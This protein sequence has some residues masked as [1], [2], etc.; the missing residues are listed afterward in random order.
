MAINV[1]QA[2]NVSK[3]DLF[4]QMALR[5]SCNLINMSSQAQGEAYGVP[6]LWQL[7]YSL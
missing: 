3:I 1:A 5:Q 7:G 4:G 6:L 2:K